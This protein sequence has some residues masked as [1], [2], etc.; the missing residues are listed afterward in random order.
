MPYGFQAAF[1]VD[2]SETLYKS[3]NWST[4]C[5]HHI[6]ADVKTYL[7]DLCW[8]NYAWCI[9]QYIEICTQV[10]FQPC[11]VIPFIPTMNEHL[12]NIWV[13][14][15]YLFIKLLRPFHLVTY[16]EQFRMFLYRWGYNTKSIFTTGRLIDLVAIKRCESIRGKLYLIYLTQPSQQL[17]YPFI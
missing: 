8:H 2:A 7:N 11:S 5:N 14:F 12:S 6:E 17:Q 1:S 16:N 15:V 9:L 13:E 4:F 3:I 10:S